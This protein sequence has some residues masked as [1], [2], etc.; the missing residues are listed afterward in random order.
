[1]NFFRRVEQKYVLSEKEY[2][3]LLDLINNHIEKDKYFESTVCNLYFDTDNDDLII[4][5]LEKPK[6]K[7]KIRLR[8]YNVPNLDSKVFLELKGK[9]KGVVF[10]RRIKLKLNEFYDYLYNDNKLND[11]QVMQE[12]DYMFKSYDLKPK[13]FLAYDRHSYYDKDDNT[14]RITFDTNLRSRVD[15]LKLDYGDEGKLYSDCKFYIMELK[16]LKGIPLWFS[17]IL[18]DLKI[19]SRS[20]SKYGNIYRKMKEDVYV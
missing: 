6:F 13:L 2:L 12:I 17:N 3:K 18:S 8:S 11:S 20:F 16:S 15:N 4:K 7:Q 9:Y 5:S 1:M 14:F 19:Y 10:K